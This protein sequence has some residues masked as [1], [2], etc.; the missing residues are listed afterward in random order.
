MK[1]RSDREEAIWIHGH[2][3]VIRRQAELL[4]TLLAGYDNKFAVAKVDWVEQMLSEIKEILDA[5]AVKREAE[6]EPP[7]AASEATPETPSAQ[8]PAEDSPPKG[9]TG[10]QGEQKGGA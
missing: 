5:E 7:V 3:S 1:L 6:A 4:R 9:E 2:L 10:E 8:L